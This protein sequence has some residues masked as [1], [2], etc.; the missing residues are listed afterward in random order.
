MEIRNHEL[1]LKLDERIVVG[2]AY[3]EAIARNATLDHTNAAAVERAVGLSRLSESHAET[4]VPVAVGDE[5]IRHIADTV[6]KFA[7]NTPE[8][9]EDIARRPD[10]PPYA[11]PHLA[12]RFELGH[13]AVK[14]VEQFADAAAA[15]AAQAAAAEA[16]AAAA[17]AQAAKA[18][19]AEAAEAAKAAMYIPGLIHESLGPIDPNA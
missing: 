11:N 17:A 4:G 5:P 9:I 12:R 18:A 1:Y 8:E 14:L 10:L 16:A 13:Q 6:R 2:A 7:D 3:R 19:A 15:E